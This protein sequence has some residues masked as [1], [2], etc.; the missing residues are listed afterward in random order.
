MDGVYSG[1]G[2]A[3]STRALVSSTALP[4][5]FVGLLFLWVDRTFSLL[6]PKGENSPGRWLPVLH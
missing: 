2:R 3:G 6:V 1:V 4:H 5:C